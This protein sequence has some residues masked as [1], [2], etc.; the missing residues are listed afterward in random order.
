MINYICQILSSK[1]GIQ[2]DGTPY[3]SDNYIDGQWV[4]FYNERERK[5]GGYNCVD[6][7][8]TEIIRN[9]FSV[10]KDQA[11]DVYLGRESSVSYCALPIDDDINLGTIFELER[12]PLGLVIDANNSWS[13]DLYTSVSN[14]YPNPQIIGQVC[15]NASN[16]N[17][18]VN[19]PIYYGD[20]TNNFRL[21][22]IHDATLMAD[23]TC[24]GGI[25]FIAPLLV[26]YG[27]NGQIQWN[28]PEATD[29]L[30]TWVST[31]DSTALTA[32][33]ANTKIVYGMAIVGAQVPTG[34]FWSLN[35]LVKANYTPVTDPTTGS[36]TY[37]FSSTPIDTN[38]TIMSASCVVS[39]Q[40]VSYWIGVDQFYYYDGVVQALPN[41]MSRDWFFNNVNLKYR[42]KIFGIAVPRY[43]EIWWYYPRGDSTENNAA[44]V[45]NVF[46]KFWYDTEINRASGLQTSLFPKPLLSDSLTTPINTRTGTH[47]YYLLWEHESGTDQVV[48]DA[49]IPIRS[50]VTHHFIDMCS[51]PNNLANSQNRLLRNRRI[52]PNFTMTGDMTL[53]ITNCKYASDYQSPGAE[54]EGPYIF[55]STTQYI[56]TAS[57]GRQVALTFSSNELGGNYQGG[58]ILYDWEIGD[59]QT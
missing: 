41:T 30:N 56:D 48:A 39:Y 55:N 17:N 25:V 59:I 8:N 27:N 37:T 34:L 28:N 3:D 10:P 43:N 49:H 7:G 15:P 58:K 21:V 31:L 38:I 2:R 18:T 45:Y 20:I 32:T 12:T 1:P 11:I 52:E 42:N 51:Q 9:M 54:V 35:S 29:P 16:I 13:F 50:N 6:Y 36:V 46:G 57:Q 53:T 44:I 4:R 33:I 40:Q 14:M 24:S 22:K 26:A 19:G 5:I 23:I 47:N